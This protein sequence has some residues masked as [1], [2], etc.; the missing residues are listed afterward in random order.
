[1]NLVVHRDPLLASV[2]VCCVSNVGAIPAAD[3]RSGAI[4]GLGSG[5]ELPPQVGNQHLFAWIKGPYNMHAAALV[6]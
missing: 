4:L 5:G 2:A 3:R 6:P 1:M